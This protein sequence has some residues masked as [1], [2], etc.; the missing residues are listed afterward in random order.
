MDKAIMLDP[1]KLEAAFKFL[2]S[3]NSGSISFEEIKCLFELG[4]FGDKMYKTMMKEMDE[5]G[6]GEITFNEFENIMKKLL[7]HEDDNCA[8]ANMYIT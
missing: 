5:D 7:I 1:A 4:D 2:D 3:D 6:D 8:N